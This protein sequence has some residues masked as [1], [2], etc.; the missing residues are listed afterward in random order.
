MTSHHVAILLLLDD[1]G[2]QATVGYLATKAQ[3]SRSATIKAAVELCH[4]KM[5]KIHGVMHIERDGYELKT[6]VYR[7][8]PRGRAICVRLREES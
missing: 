2:K 8:T 5:L 7:I 3:L 4:K 6:F 1:S